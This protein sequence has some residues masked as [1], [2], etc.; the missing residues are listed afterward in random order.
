M[1]KKCNVSQAWFD[2]TDSKGHKYS[3]WLK[4]TDNHTV[5]CLLCDK[6]INVFHNGFSAVQ[7]HESRQVHGKQLAIKLSEN[8][9]RL[10]GII[11]VAA[12]QNPH[13][14]GNSNKNLS[15][16]S[17]QD[18][19]VHA[20]I[21][22]VVKVVVEDISARACDDLNKLFYTM[23][24]G[25]ISSKFS[26]ARTK[27]SYLLTEALGPF[28]RDDLLNDIGDSYYSILYDET[29]NFKSE[30]E[31]QVSVRFWSNSEKKVVTAHLETFFWGLQQLK[32][33]YPILT[34]LLI[35]LA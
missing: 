23:F 27:F 33:F 28:C 34:R 5:Y 35:M 21:R 26:M 12:P 30:K 7:Q 4:K 16:F 11:P 25:D 32:Y 22:W 29:T 19:V 1:G 20:E 6:S 3:S 2:Q 18:S 8:Q 10:A 15:I 31:L 13:D 9:S 14:D 24:P 17:I